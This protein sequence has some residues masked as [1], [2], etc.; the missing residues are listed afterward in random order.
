MVGRQ[1]LGVLVGSV[2]QMVPHMAG[3]FIAVGMH[4]A[5]LWSTCLVRSFAQV[6]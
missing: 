6:L 2:A 3:L 1:H 5:G 4:L